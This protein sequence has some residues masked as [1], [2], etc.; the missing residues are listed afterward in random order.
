[1][2]HRQCLAA[3]LTHAHCLLMQVKS[4][5]AAAAVVRAP[6]IVVYEKEEERPNGKEV[7]YLFLLGPLWRILL[8]SSNTL[9]T[10][11]NTTAHGFM[12]SA[13]SE[14]A[15]TPP[16]D[17]SL[18][19]SAQRVCFTLHRLCSPRLYRVERACKNGAA[20]YEQR[21]KEDRRIN[22]SVDHCI[23]QRR[24]STTLIFISRPLLRSGAAAAQTRRAH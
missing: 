19:M 2:P 7:S 11:G 16:Q 5:A 18:W 12:L 10:S 20:A 8:P 4:M 22:A 1:M 15:T 13:H 17:H 14:S 6:A 23:Q 21:R 3:Q 9:I 24:C